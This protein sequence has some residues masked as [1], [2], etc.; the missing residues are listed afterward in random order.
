[1][2]VMTA[3]FHFSMRFTL[4]KLIAERAAR[5]GLVIPDLR[6]ANSWPTT[7][8]PRRSATRHRRYDVARVLW[9]PPLSLSITRIIS[10]KTARISRIDNDPLGPH[11]DPYLNLTG[12]GVRLTH[13]YRRRPAPIA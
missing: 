13:P 5:A 9:P 6:S 7:W 10:A 11:Y 1:M 8:D 2:N 3:C 12:R 4:L